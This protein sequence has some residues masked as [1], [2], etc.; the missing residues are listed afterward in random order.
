M[1]YVESFHYYRYFD[2][3]IQGDGDFAGMFY[4]PVVDNG[5][6]LK[7]VV[8]KK[9]QAKPYAYVYQELAGGCGSLSL[10]EDKE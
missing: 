10:F 9:G 6:V 5:D 8:R 3:S 2:N 4:D 1:T 7:G